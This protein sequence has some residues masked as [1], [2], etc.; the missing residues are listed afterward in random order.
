M[1]TNS[2]TKI[3]F[4][5]IKKFEPWKQGVFTLVLGAI[6]VLAQKGSESGEEEWM[7]AAIALTLFSWLNPIMGAFKENFGRY[8]LQSLG[9]FIGMGACFYFLVSAASS[10]SFAELG[11]IRFMGVAITWF[12]VLLSGFAFGFKILKNKTL[13]VE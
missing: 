4:F 1:K 13:D 8:F 9:V 2:N 5:G 11:P 3:S 10:I 6:L 7:M 12:F